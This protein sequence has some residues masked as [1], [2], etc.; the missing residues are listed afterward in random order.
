MSY[1]I[2]YSIQ[3][4]YSKLYFIPNENFY[5]YSNPFD[6]AF[7]NPTGV[8]GQEFTKVTVDFYVEPVNDPPSINGS[9]PAYEEQQVNDQK[10][11]FLKLD[12]RLSPFKVAVL[13]LSKNSA[14]IEKS[15]EVY[16]LIKRDRI[17]DFDDT[18]SIGRRYRRQD[19]I[20]TPVC[21]TIDFDTVESDNAVTLRDRDTME[22]LRVPIGDLRNEL[23]KRFLV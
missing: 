13:P 10:R 15:N 12:P 3:C 18:Q 22:Q 11:V 1:I 23:A 4:C 7:K 21:V 5:G 14:L 6:L 2:V 16:D 8:G 9:P 20:G 17:T 19:E